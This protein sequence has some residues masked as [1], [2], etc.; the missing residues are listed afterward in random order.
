MDID[1]E[2]LRI[3]AYLGDLS[4]RQALGATR[5]NRFDAL[6]N[7]VD[8]WF[9]EPLQ[10]SILSKAEMDAHH[11]KVG[12]PLPAALREW[13]RLVGNRPDRQECQNAVCT[14]QNLTVVQREFGIAVYCENQS[15]WDYF[16]RHEDLYQDDPIVW[17]QIGEKTTGTT[18]RLSQCLLAAVLDETIL[19]SELCGHG[20]FGEIAGGANQIVR[21]HVEGEVVAA[22][23]SLGQPLLPPFSPWRPDI[24]EFHQQGDLEVH[25]HGVEDAIFAAEG[26]I[27]SANSGVAIMRN[28]QTLNL[29]TEQ[30]LSLGYRWQ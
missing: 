18:C 11:G 5:P 25:F 29:L 6:P 22:L 7:F 15:N 4:A 17:L 21:R 1:Q 12:L 16:I 30:L 2:T 10:H 19:L 24:A 27:G 13:C 23:L 3:R 26:P 28:K 8:R 20:P 14:A 9:T